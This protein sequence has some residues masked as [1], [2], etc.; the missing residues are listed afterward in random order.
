MRRNE[1][2]IK[3]I[4]FKNFGPIRDCTIRTSPLTIFIG[5]NNAGKSYFSALIYLLFLI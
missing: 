5:P 2:Q 3:R 1:R 4:S